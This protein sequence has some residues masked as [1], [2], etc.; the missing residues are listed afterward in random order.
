MLSL[1]VWAG[2]LLW[3]HSSLIFLFP[4]PFSLCKSFLTINED[5]W[6]RTVILDVSEKIG[7]CC[8]VNILISQSLEHVGRYHWH[9]SHY[10]WHAWLCVLTC[11]MP[12]LQNFLYC[13]IS[14]NLKKA[15]CYNSGTEIMV[16]NPSFYAIFCPLKYVSFTWIV[17]NK[18]C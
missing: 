2:S 13:L 17:Q 14:R 15:L 18:G 3:L 6:H 5:C 12:H 8:P 4:C 11:L 7:V 10:S 9:V 1:E 16:V